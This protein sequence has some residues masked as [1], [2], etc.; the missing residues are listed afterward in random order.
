MCI[1]GQ[2]PAKGGV[3]QDMGAELHKQNAHPHIRFTVCIRLK[4]GRQSFFSSYGHRAA[5]A[6]YLSFENCTLVYMCGRDAE[7][8]CG[9]GH[10]TSCAHR[11]QRQ[12][13][14]NAGVCRI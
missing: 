3:P 8:E 9:A 13:Q 4:Q 11:T 14:F 12:A 5:D 6:D 10:V 7:E 1:A 2:G